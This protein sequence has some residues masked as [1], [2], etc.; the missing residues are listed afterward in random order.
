MKLITT[1]ALVSWLLV[2]A[3]A[4]EA[5]AQLHEITVAP[6]TFSFPSAD[7]DVSPLVT[8]PQLTITY[9]VAGN[10]NRGWTM[11]IQATDLTSAAGDVIPAGNVTWIAS[12]APPFVSSGTLSTTAQRL[13]GDPNNHAAGSQTG[14][15]TFSLRNLWT[16]NAGNYTQTVTLTVSSP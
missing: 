15:I 3:L 9:K 4:P 14:F 2:T 13:A 12:P 16:Y 5:A 8:G 6:S 10:P 1:V 11:T 7:P